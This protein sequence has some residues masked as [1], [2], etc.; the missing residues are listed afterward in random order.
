M[1]FKPPQKNGRRMIVLILQCLK[2]SVAV[3]LIFTFASILMSCSTGSKTIMPTPPEKYE[4]LGDAE[5]TGSGMLGVISTA[6]NFIPMGLNTRIESAY[7]EALKKVPGAT[8]L[9]NVTYQENWYWLGIGTLRTVTIT[10][11]AIR[12]VKQ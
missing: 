1:V 3:V 7:D 10:G 6:Y 9:T 2:K 12:E 4:K 8:A 11:E 5:G